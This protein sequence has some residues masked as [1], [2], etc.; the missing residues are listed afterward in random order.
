MNAAAQVPYLVE[1]RLMQELNGLGTARPHL[2]NRYD[3]PA[4]V[5]F[6]DAARSFGK[7]NEMA[8]NI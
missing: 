5:Q 7:R 8:A 1:A 6:V 2:A 4:G 3:F